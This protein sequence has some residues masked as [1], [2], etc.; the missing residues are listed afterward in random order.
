MKQ[1]LVVIFMV[2][3]SLSLK[4][5]HSLEKLWETDSV[6]N[7]PESVLPDIKAGIL[8]ASVM[9][10]NPN[11][12][13]GIGGVAK[14]STTGKMIDHDWITGLN[15]P[16]GLGRFGNTLYAAD[17]SDVVVIDMAK[18]KVK[19]KIPVDSA[20][21]LN[22]ITV[23]DK[24]I[25]YVSDSRTKRIHRIEGNKVSLY[26]EN[27]N[28]VNGLKAVGDELY[29][30]GGKTLWKADA[31]KKLTR[32]A[33]LPNGGDGIEPVGNGDWLF[34][35]WGGYVYYVH[36]DGKY[37]LLLDLHLEKKNTADI[38]YDPVNRIVYIPTFWKKSV[39]AYQLK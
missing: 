2:T 27:V 5:Q 37:E 23:S 13:D 1:Y 11:D 33:E 12:K 8:Y 32:I 31:N 9:G 36:A 28:G 20:K 10:N 29:I 25:V 15:S 7:L 26:M 35:C 22:D 39:M 6:I 30:A 34:S 3:A 4:A 21:F 24:G 18:G 17:L 14:L 16:K 38:G 19:L